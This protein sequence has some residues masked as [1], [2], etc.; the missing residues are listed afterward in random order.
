MVLSLS[1]V[2]KYCQELSNCIDRCHEQENLLNSWSVQV[3][4]CFEFNCRIRRLSCHEFAL[5]KLLGCLIFDN[6]TKSRQKN[7]LRKL[8]DLIGFRWN[9]E[10]I[11]V[12][13][14]SLSK[15]K[16]LFIYWKKYW[17]T[18]TIEVM[19]RGTTE[20]LFLWFKSRLMGILHYFN[21]IECQKK[22]RPSVVT[23]DHVVIDWV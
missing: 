3:N 7:S 9:F 12:K 8:I 22:L 19:R 16:W 18:N 17:A 2:E 20:R 23:T 6:L 10:Y 1:K 13:S 21:W 4:S 15:K 5:F 11:N 14:G